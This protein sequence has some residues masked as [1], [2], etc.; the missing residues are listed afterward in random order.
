MAANSR[1]ELPPSRTVEA[2]A[3]ERAGDETGELS[4]TKGIAAL[5]DA[6]KGLAAFGKSGTP[7]QRSY[8]SLCPANHVGIDGTTQD[9]S[10]SIEQAA[11]GTEIGGGST[12]AA[13]NG[14]ATFGETGTPLIYPLFTPFAY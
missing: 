7:L 5:T 2:G 13:R 12:T 4:T 10:G 9:G 3:A 6:S 11:V 14:G 1:V 8:F